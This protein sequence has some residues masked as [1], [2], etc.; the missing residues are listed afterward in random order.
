MKGKGIKTNVMEECAISI[1]AAIC[2]CLCVRWWVRA[3]AHVCQIEK[4]KEKVR[5][6]VVRSKPQR[7]PKQKK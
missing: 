6:W 7:R 5:A 4:V 2:I 1:E 3:R